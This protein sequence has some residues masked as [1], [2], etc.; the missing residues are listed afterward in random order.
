[1]K[2]NKFILIC[3]VCLIV[4]CKFWMLFAEPWRNNPAASSTISVAEQT[5]TVKKSDNKNV[6]V[7][8]AKYVESKNADAKVVTDAAVKTET[9]KPATV[10]TESTKAKPVEKPFSGC[11]S[12]FSSDMVANTINGKT[13]REYRA[14][15]VITCDCV[16]ADG[17]IE[18]TVV[19]RYSSDPKNVEMDCHSKCGEICGTK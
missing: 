16:V 8:E 17:I 1:M 14:T 5:S 11:G 6:E 9:V 12:S 2:E 3:V 4:F 15:N 7:T 10:Q 19:Y 18:K 13:V